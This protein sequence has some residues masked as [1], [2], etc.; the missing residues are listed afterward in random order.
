MNDS[1]MF[2]CTECDL[3]GLD[4]ERT[5]WSTMQDNAGYKKTGRRK[6]RQFKMTK[7]VKL[8]LCLTEHYAMKTYMEVNV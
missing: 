5:E 4:A 2:L 1:S 8:S 7:K 3:E 6:N